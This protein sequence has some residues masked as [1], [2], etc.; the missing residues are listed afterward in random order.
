MEKIKY[1]YL[2]KEGVYYLFIFIDIIHYFLFRKDYEHPIGVFMEA[3]YETSVVTLIKLILVFISAGLFTLER[4]KGK[5][6][7]IT[8]LINILGMIMVFFS[9]KEGALRHILFLYSSI[10][11]WIL[12]IMGVFQI[13]WSVKKLR[14]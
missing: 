9:I 6:A 13:S 10:S 11:L 1:Y 12:F 7:G 8:I 14:Q 3:L 4:K 5:S 2:R